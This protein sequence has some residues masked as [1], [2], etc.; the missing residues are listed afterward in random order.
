MRLVK[1]E[2]AS[3]VFK[4]ND[5]VQ[6]PRGNGAIT[7]VFLSRARGRH[8]YYVRLEGSRAGQ[9]FSQ[10]ELKPAGGRTGGTHRTGAKAGIEG[11]G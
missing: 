8:T 1:R 11:R 6:T 2:P 7:H 9:V 3:P 4:I 10:R 5:R